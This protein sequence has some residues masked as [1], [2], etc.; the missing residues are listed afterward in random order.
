MEEQYEVSDINYWVKAKN[1][2][3]IISSVK[4]TMMIIHNFVPFG[5]VTDFLNSLPLADQSTIVYVSLNKTYDYIRPFLKT[6]KPKMFIVDGVS[7]GLFAQKEGFEGV[8]FIRPPLTLNNLFE[9]IEITYK[10]RSPDYIFVDALSQL[11]NFSGDG[12]DS[13]SFF[14]FSNKLHQSIGESTK[15]VFIYIEDPA[16]PIKNLPNMQLGSIIRMEVCRS[17]IYWKD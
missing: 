17:E 15:L 6:I 4:G 3:E 12:G 16:H 5:E 14:L 2:T 9:I 11:L 13:G 8:S 7:A 10:E 1:I